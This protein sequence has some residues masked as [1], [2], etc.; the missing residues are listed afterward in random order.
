[1]RG[2]PRFW[3][4]ARWCMSAC[5]KV[6]SSRRPWNRSRRRDIYLQKN[7]PFGIWPRPVRRSPPRALVRAVGWRIHRRYP[8]CRP[9]PPPLLLYDISTLG[10]RHRSDASAGGRTKL[11]KRPSLVVV[12]DELCCCFFLCWPCSP[13]IQCNT[14]STFALKTHYSLR[15]TE[16]VVP[17]EILNFAYRL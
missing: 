11:A 3:A 14:Q 4:T 16:P 12:A 6:A 8:C 15:I 17:L 5:A 2:P 13:K 9:L 10:C 7:P 1:M